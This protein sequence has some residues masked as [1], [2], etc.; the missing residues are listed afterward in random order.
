MQ[1][2]F[3]SQKAQLRTTKAHHLHNTIYLGNEYK[4]QMCIIFSNLAIISKRDKDHRIEHCVA[5]IITG[6]G[7]WAV[8][9]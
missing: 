7:L 6:S 2:L 3:G 1:G 4:K 8:N 9:D 5:I